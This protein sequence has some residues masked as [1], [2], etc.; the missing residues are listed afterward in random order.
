MR[1]RTL[2]QS[3]ALLAASAVTTALFGGCSSQKPAATSS[4][5]NGAPLR[6]GVVPW[7]GWSSTKIAEVKGFFQEAGVNVQ[8]TV[9]QTVS[10]VNTALLAK[11]IDIAGLVAV[12]LVVLGAQVPDL[13]FFMVSDYSGEVDAIL[14]RGINS[15]EDLRGKKLAREDIPYEVTFVGRYLESI[16]LTEQDVE[17]ISLPSADAATALIAGKVDAAATYAPFIGNVLKQSPD[18]KVLFSA[19]DS[20]IIINGFAAQAEVLKTRREEILAYMRAY[21]KAMQ[22]AKTNESE[23]LDITAKWTGITAPEVKAQLAQVDVYDLAKNKSVAFNSGNPLNVAN[24]IDEGGK[25]LVKA[26]KAAK[27]LDGKSLIDPSFVES[28]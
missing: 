12:D 17:I 4:A 18:A 19:K 2:I 28:F 21:D 20:N 23:A 3:S 25:V 8:Q 13:K 22:F 11:Q 9:F 27:T 24:S 7:I 26:K 15:P 16:G 1:R 10:E 14:G 6:I 5:T